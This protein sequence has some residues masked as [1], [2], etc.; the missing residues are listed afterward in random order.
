MRSK[1]FLWLGLMFTLTLVAG[2]GEGSTDTSANGGGARPDNAIDVLIVYSPES[3]Q[4]MPQIIADFN[5]L[6]AEGKNPLT[7][8]ALSSGERPVYVTGQ[9]PMTGSS[10][11]VMQGIVNAIIAPNNANVYRPT[12]F[13]PSVSHWL[14]LAN[15]QSG[16]ELFNLAEARATALSPVIIG[17]WESRAEA[18]RRTIGSDEIGLQ[19]LLDVLNSPE[20]WADYGIPDGRRAVFYGHT[21]PFI[22]ST[23]LSTT[24]AEYYACARQNGFTERRLSINQVT[25]ADVQSCVQNIEQLVRHYSSRTEDFLEYIARGPNYLDFVALEETDLICINTG[26]RQGEE[27]CNKPQERLVAIYPKEGTFWHEHPFGI[28]NADWV[29]PEQREAARIFTD[30][31][32]LPPQQRIIMSYGFRP[33]NPDV[34]L[35]FPFVEENGVDPDGP[36]TILDVPAPEVITAIQQNWSVVRK[37]AD[38]MLLMDVSGSMIDQGKIDQ[39]KQ[40]AE[41]FINN[42]ESNNRVGLAV[43][44]S[45]VNV[46]VPLDNFENNRE[47]LLQAIRSLRAEGGTELF[48]ALRDTVTHLNEQSSEERIRAVVLLSD[49]ADTGTMGATLADALAPITATSDDL[50]P[51][52][53]IPVAYGSDADISALNNIAQVS[54]TRVQSGDPAS[55]S[56]VLDI[57]GSYF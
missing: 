2:C 44:S 57:I 41:A 45:D 6:Y 51:V 20:G 19:D 56:A 13:Q 26:G 7:G 21:D 36:A 35:E 49:G 12:I 30:Y 34:P 29:T 3:E 32:L 33:A 9:P 47:S 37:Q 27:V 48:A 28:V 54:A 52:I 46:L 31:V 17:M 24:I 50:N 43:F 8:E 40:A 53:V 18:I 16:R 5:R 38:V 15:L 4:Y 25:D 11:T 22:S 23:G 55:I 14:A 1:W 39:A 10:G 42:M